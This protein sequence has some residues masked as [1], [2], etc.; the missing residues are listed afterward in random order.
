MHKTPMLTAMC[1]HGCFQFFSLV[2]GEVDLFHLHAHVVHDEG[3]DVAVSSKRFES[4]LP[5]PWPALLSMRQL[6]GL[7]LLFWG[8]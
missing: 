2:L 6:L 1:G 4:G 8:L 5:P 3:K 7:L